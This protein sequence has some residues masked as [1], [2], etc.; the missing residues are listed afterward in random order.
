[1]QDHDKD[2]TILLVLS[3]FGPRIVLSAHC[4]LISDC[5]FFFCL[6]PLL[7][8]HIIFS[9]VWQKLVITTRFFVRQQFR[10]RILFFPSRLVSCICIVVM[11]G[12]GQAISI[13]DICRPRSTELGANR[14]TREM[15]IETWGTCKVI[16][17]QL[18]RFQTGSNAF[19]V[20]YHPGSC[21]ETSRM[22][23]ELGRNNWDEISHIKRI[24]YRLM[25]LR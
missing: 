16:N 4:M 7:F 10:N 22:F 17:I 18:C 2:E 19:I 20:L 5:R 24:D 6:V 14:S 3:I 25:R 8:Y 12:G 21:R 11:Q 23:C 15:G 1:M 9:T 13:H